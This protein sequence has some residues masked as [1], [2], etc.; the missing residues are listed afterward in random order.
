MIVV[1]VGRSVMAEEGRAACDGSDRI[2]NGC[3]A[4]VANG[5]AGCVD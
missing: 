5:N 2:W 4:T 1:V 3:S